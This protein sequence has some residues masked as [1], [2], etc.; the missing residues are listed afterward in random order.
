MGKPTGRIRLV[1]AVY[2]LG[3]GGS[4]TLAMQI[5]GALNRDGRYAC[6]LYGVEHGGPLTEALAA[7]GIPYRVFSRKRRLDWRLALVRG[8]RL[9]HLRKRPACG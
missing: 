4:E 8:I 2:S 3:M 9:P 7:D 1:Q 6:S 5:A